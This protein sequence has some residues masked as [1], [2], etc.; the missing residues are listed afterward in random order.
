MSKNLSSHF[1]FRGYAPHQLR[2]LFSV[3]QRQGDNARASPG[4][5]LAVSFLPSVARAKA[6]GTGRDQSSSPGKEWDLPLQQLLWYSV[7]SFEMLGS[8]P[9]KGNLEM[10]AWRW[11]EAAPDSGPFIMHEATGIQ[12]HLGHDGFIEPQLN[13]PLVHATDFTRKIGNV[14]LWEIIFIL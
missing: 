6:S 2:N 8:F 9:V 3:T 12:Q 14:H 5:V 4:L 10:W 1:S 11:V 13:L 7:Q